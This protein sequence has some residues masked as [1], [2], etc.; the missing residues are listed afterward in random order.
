MIL[1]ENGRSVEHGYGFVAPP[2]CLNGWT[3]GS[4]PVSW[5]LHF[6][7]GLATLFALWKGGVASGG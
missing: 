5:E 7:S 2:A 3:S 4:R 1:R 6:G